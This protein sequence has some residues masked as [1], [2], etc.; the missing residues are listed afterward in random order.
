[1]IR[2]DLEDLAQELQSR[3]SLFIRV[4]CSP[5]EIVVVLVSYGVGQ[6]NKISDKL[7]PGLII[8]TGFSCKLT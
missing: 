3:H 4:D 1:M 7:R 8:M 6:V 5:F 2:K